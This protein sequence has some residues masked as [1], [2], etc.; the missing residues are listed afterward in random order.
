MFMQESFTGRKTAKILKP[1]TI[2]LKLLGGILVF[3]DFSPMC[4]G[5]FGKKRNQRRCGRVYLHCFHAMLG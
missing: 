4:R 1:L 2:I 5:G 3:R